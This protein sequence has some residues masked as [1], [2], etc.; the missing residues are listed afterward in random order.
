MLYHYLQGAILENIE[1]AIFRGV[2]DRSSGEKYKG[3]GHLTDVENIE[4]MLRLLG[5]YKN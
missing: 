5:S 1:C 4:F 3:S 2:L